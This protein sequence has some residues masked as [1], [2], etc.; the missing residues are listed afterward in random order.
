MVSFKDMNPI[1]ERYSEQGGNRS[2]GE[3]FVGAGPRQ[4]PRME[5][6]ELI[7]LAEKILN[8]N[9]ALRFLLRLETE[10]LETLIAC[11]RLR[12]ESGDK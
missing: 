12:V 8:S 5:K 1:Q 4:R 10:D 9:A 2:A 6:E 11:I 3:V 7:H